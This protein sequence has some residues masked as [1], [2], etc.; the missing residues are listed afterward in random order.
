MTPSTR[1][2]RPLSLDSD[3]A[4]LAGDSAGALPRVR[5]ILR[6]VTRPRLLVS[7]GEASGDL[8]ASEL[9]RHLRSSGQDFAAFGLGG[10]GLLAQQ[11]RLVAHVRDL[12]VLGLAEIV[13]SLPRLR[14]AF[15]ALL[16]DVD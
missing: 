12:A 9:L 8:Y 6:A 13:T 1:V 10:D 7:C 4:P 3:I 16:A 11:V 2:R 5:H 15:R 14:R